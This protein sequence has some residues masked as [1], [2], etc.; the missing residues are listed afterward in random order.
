MLPYLALLLLLLFSIIFDN[1]KYKWKVFHINSFFLFLFCAFRGNGDG[2][3][4]TYIEYSK[5]IVS[6]N[7]VLDFTFPMEI[8]FR[9]I[10]FFLNSL[11]LGGQGVIILM[12]M[13]SLFPTFYIISKLS[14]KPS[15]S[16]LVFFPFFLI[17]DMHSSRTAVAAAFG[18][19]GAL[20]LFENRNVKASIF[21][22]I[23][24]S[25]HSSA[26]ILCLLFFRRCKLS[27]IIIMMI[28]SLV[29]Q[30]VYGVK[31]LLL[32]ILDSLGLD[33]FRM[34]VEIYLSQED[35]VY[36]IPLYDPRNVL[37]II[38]SLLVIYY[39]RSIRTMSQSFELNKMFA[40]GCVVFILFSDLAIFS[41]R[42]SYFFLI[43]SYI[44][45]PIL[46]HRLDLNCERSSLPRLSGSYLFAFAYSLMASAII[47]S[48]V[49]YVFYFG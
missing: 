31:E 44:V 37:Q 36:D 9:I 46:S 23:A 7:D 6:V 40:F 20:S 33:F 13:L 19:L 45:V 1:T 8:G 17:M 2:D 47:F 11:N 28:F 25:F 22:A 14:D 4:F 35:Y 32:T 43:T 15:L 48:Y 5:L 49:E 24:I 3:Y 18:L 42:L 39:Y 29:F 26:I 34:K 30:S 41:I 16:L 21:F 12:S 10:S 27:S 38:I